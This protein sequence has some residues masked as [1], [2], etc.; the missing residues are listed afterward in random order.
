MEYGI[1]EVYVKHDY[2]SSLRVKL[3]KKDSKGNLF[4]LKIGENGL[5]VVSE[6]KTEKKLYKAKDGFLPFQLDF[7]LY[8]IYESGQYSIP[9][10]KYIKHVGSSRS[11]KSYSLEEKSIRL[12]EEIHN[13]RITVWRDSRE[14]LGNTIWKDFRKIFPLS[15]RSYKF[16]RNTVPIYFDNGSVIE[17][18]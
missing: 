5:D 6:I 9:R 4:L 13:Y 8:Y 7:D 16:P 15:G 17:P 2:F 1:T 18:H 10:Y 3:I 14:S 11:S 12:C